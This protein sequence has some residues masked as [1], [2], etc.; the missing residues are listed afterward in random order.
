MLGNM[1]AKENT[2]CGNDIFT[3]NKSQS[4]TWANE[5]PTCRVQRAAQCGAPRLM[6]LHPAILAHTLFYFPFNRRII[7]TVCVKQCFQCLPLFNSEAACNR[8]ARTRRLDEGTPPL[9]LVLRDR[10]GRKRGDTLPRE[11]YSTT[12]R[13]PWGSLGKEFLLDFSLFRFLSHS[14]SLLLIWLWWFITEN[15]KHSRHR[16]EGFGARV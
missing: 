11:T 3:W 14:D 1:K 13:A 2:P 5:R 15:Q 9:G 16:N 6:N 4:N 8:R 12:R 10:C 7:S